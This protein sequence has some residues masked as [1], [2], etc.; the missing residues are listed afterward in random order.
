[1]EAQTLTNRIQQVIESNESKGLKFKPSHQY[2]KSIGINKH[3]F[4]KIVRNEKQPDLSQLG[5]IAN[6]LG[7][8]PMDLIEGMKTNLSQ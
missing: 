8:T 3:L 7:V 4:H 5:A 1:M 2:F 6:S